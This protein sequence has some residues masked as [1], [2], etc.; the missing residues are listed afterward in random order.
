[1]F[2]LKKNYITKFKRVNPNVIILESR[3][4]SLDPVTPQSLSIYDF[5]LLSHTG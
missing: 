1:M 4:K 2:T 5:A 3:Y